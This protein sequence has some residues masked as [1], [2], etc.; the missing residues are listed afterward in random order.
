MGESHGILY[1]YNSNVNLLVKHH[2]DINLIDVFGDIKS[3]NRP[4]YIYAPI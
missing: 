3:F 4:K 2:N 1:Y